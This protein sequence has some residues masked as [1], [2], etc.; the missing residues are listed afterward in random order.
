MQTA[1]ITRAFRAA[2]AAALV[3]CAAHP[4]ETAGRAQSHPE[5]PPSP[6]WRPA[7]GY[8]ALFAPAAH[9]A[10]YQFFTHPRGLDELLPALADAPGA[11]RT[12]GGWSARPLLPLDAFGQSGSYD[13]M[14]VA[15]LY[16]SSRAQVARGPRQEAGHVVESWTLISPYPDVGMTRLEPGTLLV[17]LR[18]P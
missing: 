3:L 6:E 5:R 17:V 13:R 12:P 15:R 1:S 7:P 18:L 16:G 9:A 11:V 8:S 2:A 14:A 4:D 10:A